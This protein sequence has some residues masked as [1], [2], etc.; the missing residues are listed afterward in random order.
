MYKPEYPAPI[1]TTLIR[2]ELSTG[3]SLIEVIFLSRARRAVEVS[4]V[5]GL[6][7]VEEL[8]DVNDWTASQLRCEKWCRMAFIDH[9]SQVTLCSP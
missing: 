6:K 8:G 4:E 3:S 9:I 2:R 1:T 7:F 5:T